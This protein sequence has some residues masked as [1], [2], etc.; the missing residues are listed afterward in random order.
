MGILET[1]SSRVPTV[2]CVG[3]AST[4]CVRNIYS[5]LVI[6]EE[7]SWCISIRNECMRTC[8]RGIFASGARRT[9]GPCLPMQEY[10]ISSNK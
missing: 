6:T 5:T 8:P 1:G 10:S 9:D 2:L 3:T 7:K 4:L